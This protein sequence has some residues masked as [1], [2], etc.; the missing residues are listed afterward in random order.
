MR[1]TLR[2]LADAQKSYLRFSRNLVAL[3][4]ASTRCEIASRAHSYAS[5]VRSV[6]P[7]PDWR[8]SNSSRRLLAE[9]PLNLALYR[10][11]RQKVSSGTSAMLKLRSTC[12]LYTSDAADDLLCVDLGG[13]RIIK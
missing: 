2:D 13:R 7:S 1:R 12:L 5:L 4:S 8:S 10:S 9:W 6:R 3:R 11:L